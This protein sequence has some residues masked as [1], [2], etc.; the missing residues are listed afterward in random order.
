MCLR[1]STSL[2]NFPFCVAFLQN[3]ILKVLQLPANRI[4]PED[5]M[6]SISAILPV[7]VFFFYK[8]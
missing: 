4:S 2:A 3:S 5:H 1:G 8:E 6:F 7:F